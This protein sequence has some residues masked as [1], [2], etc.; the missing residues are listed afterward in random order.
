MYHPSAKIMHLETRHRN[1]TPPKV[2]SAAEAIAKTVSSKNN[3][4]VHSAAAA[5]QQLYG[6][7]CSHLTL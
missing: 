7:H 3:I 4:F 1:H 6:R 5:P 2:V